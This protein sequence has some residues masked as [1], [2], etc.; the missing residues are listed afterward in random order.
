M[1]K[2]ILKYDVDESDEG[3]QYWMQEIKKGTPREAIEKYFRDVALKDI[4]SI[5]EDKII[6]LLDD[7]DKGK[8]I[9]VVVPDSRKDVLLV[10]S[11]LPSMKK[12]YPEYNIYFATRLEFFDIL[13]GNKNIHKVIPFIEEMGNPLWSEGSGDKE[14]LFEIAFIPT[15]ERNYMHNNKDKI[16]LC[17]S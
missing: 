8:R 7:E 11:L 3:F 13:D 5:D 6:K 15:L 4:A 9:I 14:G 10:S 12:T 2:E 16:E 1:Y 17:T